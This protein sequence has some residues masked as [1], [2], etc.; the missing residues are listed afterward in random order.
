[1]MVV[2]EYP[3]VDQFSLETGIPTLV[4]WLE[5]RKIRIWDTEARGQLISGGG[6]AFDA[7]FTKYLAELEC[8]FPPTQIFDCVGFVLSQ[9]VTFEHEDGAEGFRRDATSFVQERGDTHR[10]DQHI[11]SLCDALGLDRST[12][13]TPDDA[14]LAL[15]Q[16][17]AVLRNSIDQRSRSDFFR[18]HPNITLGFQT[19]FGPD[20][21]DVA[22]VLR[23]FY[24]VDLLNLQWRINDILITA[25]NFVANPKTNTKLG[26]V[27]R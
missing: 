21:D 20:A 22:K 24:L 1:M 19:G 2:L 16:S 26:K 13:S 9:A 25:Q 12:F 3:F 11:A 14:L 23:L 27:G 6:P 7:A 18:Q 17:A 8:P 4:S 10:E 5:D 15:C